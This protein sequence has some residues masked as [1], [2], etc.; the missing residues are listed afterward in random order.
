MAP[1]A[2]PSVSLPDLAE[3]DAGGDGYQARFAPSSAV[4]R[5]RPCE[6]R[7]GRRNGA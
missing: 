2:V 4:A 7:P 1:I 5:G 3:R 6:V